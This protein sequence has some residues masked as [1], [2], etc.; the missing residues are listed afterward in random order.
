MPD[1]SLST[2]E[3]S[4][5]CRP[6]F[7]ILQNEDVQNYLIPP[8]PGYSDPGFVE[9]GKRCEALNDMLEISSRLMCGRIAKRSKKYHLMDSK[10]DKE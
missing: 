6:L 10:I 7:L 5:A 9:F 3:R 2:I 4:T 1:F 8:D